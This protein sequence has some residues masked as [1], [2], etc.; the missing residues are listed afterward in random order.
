MGR[1]GAAR[2]D[3]ANIVS[4]RTAS[5]CRPVTDCTKAIVCAIR[6]SRSFFQLMMHLNPPGP[7]ASGVAES[8]TKSSGCVDKPEF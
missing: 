2:G 5:S 8:T 3:T 1:T 7:F 4:S 6:E